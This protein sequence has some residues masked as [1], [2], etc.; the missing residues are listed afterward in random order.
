[1]PSEHPAAEC[2]DHIVEN[3]EAIDEYVAGLDRAAFEGDR[4]TRDAVERCLQRICEA[5]HRLGERAEALLPGHPR[6]K[7]RGMGNQLRH[8]YDRIS[9]DVVWTTVREE[10][11]PLAADARRVRDRLLDEER[12]R[13]GRTA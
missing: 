6:H 4:R 5:A 3:A 11:P 9:R 7:V 12:A 10:L 13:E 1:M 8:A 2:L